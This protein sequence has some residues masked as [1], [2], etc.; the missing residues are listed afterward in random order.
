MKKITRNIFLIFI[1]FVVIYGLTD[2]IVPGMRVRHLKN[3]EIPEW[4]E[5]QYIDIGGSSRSGRSLE[6]VEDIVIHYVGNPES[7]AQGNRDY[8]NNSN[9]SV[10]AHFVVGLEGEIIQC[11]PL[12]ER[13]AASNNRNKDTISIEVCHPTETGEF[14]SET[15]DS[16]VKLTKWLCETCSLDENDVIRHYDVTGKLCPLYF[17][18]YEDAWN[19]FLK[20]VKY[21]E[22]EE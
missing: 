1:A 15:Y 21:Y 9:S 18:N 17:V 22:L 12:N 5:Q 13:S 10:S 8:F 7:T 20:D 6:G 14:T 19:N 3:I 11:L 16:L 2:F 4:I